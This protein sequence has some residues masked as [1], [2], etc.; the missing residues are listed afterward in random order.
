MET[1][2]MLA[3]TTE[4]KS[5]FIDTLRAELFNKFGKDIPE[6]YSDTHKWSLIS[7]IESDTIDSYQMLYVNDKFWM[8]SGGMVREFNGE[9]VYQAGF[10]AFKS[11]SNLPKGLYFPTFVHDNNTKFQIERAKQHGCKSVIISFNDYNERLFK[12]TYQTILPKVFPKDTFV[13]SDTLIEFNGVPQWILTM[14][15]E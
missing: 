1:V 2:R 12:L 9:K 8:A 10:R 7:L 13:P 4:N 5:E 6:N 14:K 3:L 15:L 11:A